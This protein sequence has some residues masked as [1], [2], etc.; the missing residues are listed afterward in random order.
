V[1]LHKVVNLLIRKNDQN[2]SSCRAVRGMQRRDG[3]F[4]NFFLLDSDHEDV[5]WKFL[6]IALGKHESC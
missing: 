5:M 2:R 1:K 4:S 3:A 6:A